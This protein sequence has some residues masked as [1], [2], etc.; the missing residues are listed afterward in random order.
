MLTGH[1]VY[2]VSTVGKNRA[3]TVKA[4][5]NRL[6]FDAPVHEVVFDNPKQSPELK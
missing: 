4:D 3:G 2:I 6:G 5:V 1:H